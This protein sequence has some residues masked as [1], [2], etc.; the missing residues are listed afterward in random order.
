MASFVRAT[1]LYCMARH[2]HGSLTDPG[3]GPAIMR[4]NRSH[5]GRRLS[6]AESDTP[7]AITTCW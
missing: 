5:R 2:A 1:R 3:R 7:A 4:W 6:R